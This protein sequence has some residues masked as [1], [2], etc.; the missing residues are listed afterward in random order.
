MQDGG[1]LFASFIVPLGAMKFN[2]DA[3]SILPLLGTVFNSILE[4]FLLCLAGYLLASR[5]TF[6]KKT[7]KQLNYLNVT[8]FTPALLFSKVAFFLSPAKLRELWIVPICFALIT[9]IS[10]VVAYTLSRICRLKDSQ[11]RFA[12]AA[13][14]FM[15]SNSLP[16]ALMQ[17]IVIS[18]PGLHWGE[19]D[20]HN[21]ML[22]RALSYLVLH[23]TFGM[24]L[25]WSYGVRLLRKSDDQDEFV[26]ESADETDSE[27]ESEHS[28]LLG[29]DLEEYDQRPSTSTLT[30][31]DVD[32]TSGPSYLRPPGKRRQVR[33]SA[34]YKSFPNSPGRPEFRL[35]DMTPSDLSDSD[36]DNR[37]ENGEPASVRCP[38]PYQRL[39]IKQR[40]RNTWD[41]FCKFMTAPL[42]A[43]LL[44]VLVACTPPLQHAM[45]LHLPPV[46]GALKS[47]GN[48]SIPLTLV[49]LGAYFYP[50]APDNEA[51]SREGGQYRDGDREGTRKNRKHVDGRHR[52]FAP[53]LKLSAESLTRKFRELLHLNRSRRKR[54]RDKGETR[55]VIVAVFSRMVITPLLTTPLIALAAKFDWHELFDDPVFV[56]STMLL[57]WSPPALTLAQITNATS[58]DA[59]ECLIS[60]TIFWS[61]CVVTPPSTV[62]STILGLLL[63][64][65]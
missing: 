2:F 48:C 10:M 19:D 45:E 33:H 42:W 47:A 56:V 1:A 13:A 44:S 16:I 6:D 9:G 7:Q 51:S 65:L 22:G 57:L 20:N 21:A 43:S 24:I 30:V 59:F 53:A 62:I 64:R 5:G 32:S 8:L 4:V 28:P 14:M 54:R 41:G 38:L 18:V 23:S 11:R 25:R 63:V 60:R 34:F 12:M 35:P 17:S 29:R 49:V 26:P 58:G 52:Q 46:K 27:N 40:L 55:T 37:L 3:K 50:S 36:E 61:Y 39:S 15:N 31:P